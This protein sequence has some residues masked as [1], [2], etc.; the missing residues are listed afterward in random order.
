MAGVGSLYAWPPEIHRD[1][2]RR[3]VVRRESSFQ[4]GFQETPDTAPSPETDAQCLSGSELEAHGD[5]SL[6]WMLHPQVRPERGAGLRTRLEHTDA[7][8]AVTMVTATV[9]LNLVLCRFSG[10]L[11]E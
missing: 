9:A 3:T 5:V 10:V 11:K 8:F 6:A 1:P 7:G 4:E 2:K